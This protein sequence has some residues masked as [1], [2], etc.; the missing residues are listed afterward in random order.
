VDCWKYGATERSRIFA[1]V[2]GEQHYDKDLI[3]FGG[4]R[5]YGNFEF[6]FGRDG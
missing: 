5:F 2:F 6:N 3:K 1:F 4:L